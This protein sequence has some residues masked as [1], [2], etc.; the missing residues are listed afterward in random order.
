[1]PEKII[2]MY[3]TI[4]PETLSDNEVFP[5]IDNNPTYQALLARFMKAEKEESDEFIISEALKM[6]SE[7][8]WDE[9]DLKIRLLELLKDRHF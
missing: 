5:D 4:S 3:K 6:Y 9:Y 2:E 7:L 1:M 8:D